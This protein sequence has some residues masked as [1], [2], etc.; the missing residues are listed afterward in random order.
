MR[1]NE[2]PAL[3]YEPTNDAD[4]YTMVTAPIQ[5]EFLKDGG[6]EAPGDKRPTAGTPSNGA[7]LNSVGQVWGPPAG[8]A[9]ENSFAPPAHGR[10]ADPSH[11]ENR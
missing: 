4:D 11:L 2:S 9:I 8:Y 5:P 7:E 3:V 10:C 6:A 1:D